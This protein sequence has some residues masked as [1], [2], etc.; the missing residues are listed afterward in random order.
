M[1]RQ[2]S[3][4]LG[5]LSLFGAPSPACRLGSGT[6]WSPSSRSTPRHR[7]TWLSAGGS[8]ALTLLCYP[9]PRLGRPR[10]GG[11]GGPHRAYVSGSFPRRDY[12]RRRC[13]MGSGPTDAP[14]GLVTS[15]LHHRLSGRTDLVDEYQARGERFD[16]PERLGQPSLAFADDAALDLLRPQQHAVEP[17]LLRGRDRQDR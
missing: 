7:I 16:T 4:P 10:L 5:A 6:H 11:C 15:A 12:S 13:R 2:V 14:A 3:D 9:L 17:G 8:L 1:P